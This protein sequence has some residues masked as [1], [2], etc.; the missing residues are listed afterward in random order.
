MGITE[1]LNVT[2]RRLLIGVAVLAAFLFVLF[3]LA[4]PLF[5]S[6]HHRRLCY[7]IWAYLGWGLLIPSLYDRTLWVPMCL[8]AI[9]WA[10]GLPEDEDQ[11]AD[12]DLGKDQAAD[13]SVALTTTART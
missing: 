12:E 7:T 9:C 5:G 10:S 11:S 13:E 8:A 6:S 4:R 2:P 1:K 3:A